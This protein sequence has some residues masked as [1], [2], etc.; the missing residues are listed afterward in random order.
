MMPKVVIAGAGLMGR[1]H[2][3][4]ASHCGAQIVGIFDRDRGADRALDLVRELIA[5]DSWRIPL[6]YVEDGRFE[7][8]GY[9]HVPCSQAYFGTADILPRLR[10]FQPELTDA[11]GDELEAELRP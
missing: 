10:H 3:S 5:K 9:I 2:M 1:W 11:D 8:S 4:A 6:V 7:P